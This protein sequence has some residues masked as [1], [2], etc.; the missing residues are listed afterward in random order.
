MSSFVPETLYDLLDGDA[1]VH[2]LVDRFYDI[3]D[4]DPAAET[5]RDMH[6]EDL[7]ESRNKRYEFLSGWTGGPRNL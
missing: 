7:A 5:V 6:P 4:R 3:M 1:G 2:R